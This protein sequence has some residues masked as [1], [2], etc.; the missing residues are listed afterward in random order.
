MIGH[1]LPC[2]QLDGFITISINDIIYNEQLLDRFLK[3]TTCL[4]ALE[5]ADQYIIFHIEIE[6]DSKQLEEAITT[7]S[8]DLGPSEIIFKAIRQLLLYYCALIF[9]I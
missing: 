3:A 5:L 8:R 4:K 6:T 2:M 9:W 7:Y 1:P